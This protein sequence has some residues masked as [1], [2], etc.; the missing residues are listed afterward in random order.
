VKKLAIIFFSVIAIVWLVSLASRS[1]TPSP[2]A[3]AAKAA[4]TQDFAD[5][6]SAA[7][8]AS[9]KWSG[10]QVEKAG[11]N[12]YTLV[13]LYQEMPSGQQEVERD[14][15]LVMQAALSELVKLGRNPAQE[16][17]FVTVRAH[18]PET[19]ATGQNVVRVFGR[20]VYDYNND[21]I[22]YKAQK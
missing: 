18:K 20:S 19:G 21:T 7:M 5:A 9:P 8:K 11:G 1:G 3:H 15:K 4:T 16:H 22:T 14:T 10:I 2:E 13:L 6:V 17:I 12:D